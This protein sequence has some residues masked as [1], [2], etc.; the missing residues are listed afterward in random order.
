MGSKHLG[1]DIEWM[2]YTQ[3]RPQLEMPVPSKGNVGGCEIV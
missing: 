3:G 2:T 1:R